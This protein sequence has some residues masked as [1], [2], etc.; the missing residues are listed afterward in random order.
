[1]LCGD[2]DSV[3]KTFYV[4]QFSYV[5]LIGCDRQGLVTGETANMHTAVIT[6]H[7][8]IHTVTDRQT[9][10]QRQPDTS[11]QLQRPLSLT[12]APIRHKH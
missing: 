7:T 12:A 4:L 5:V 1:M 9:E 8:L 6:T 3:R 10:R 11:Y 2:S